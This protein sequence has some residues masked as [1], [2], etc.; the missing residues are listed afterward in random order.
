[1]VQNVDDKLKRDMTERELSI[2]DKMGD[3]DGDTFLNN[4]GHDRVD[5][6]EGFRKTK[7]NMHM[8]HI[9]T[10]SWF[11]FVYNRITKN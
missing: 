5:I 3:P 10:D 9:P 1:M 2:L 11:V 7:K 4:Q 6:I 8:E